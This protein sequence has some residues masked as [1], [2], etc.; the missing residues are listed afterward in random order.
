MHNFSTKSDHKLLGAI[1]KWQYGIDMINNQNCMAFNIGYKGEIPIPET[2][3]SIDDEQTWTNYDFNSYNT[4]YFVFVGSKHIKNLA[5]ILRT[6]KETFWGTGPKT[7]FIEG[8][9]E[10]SAINKFLTSSY[11]TTVSSIN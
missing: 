11:T 10:N 2:S 7:L 9:F 4:C 3:I 1:T 5:K 8:K 6:L